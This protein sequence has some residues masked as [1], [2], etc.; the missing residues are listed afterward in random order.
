MRHLIIRKGVYYLRMRVPTDVRVYFPCKE[1]K[2]TLKTRD[3]KKACFLVKLLV[4]E[5]DKIFF[6]IRSGVLSHEEIQKL[7]KDY[8]NKTVDNDYVRDSKFLPDSDNL[9]PALFRDTGTAEIESEVYSFLKEKGVSISGDSAEF[10]T[11]C[12]VIVNTT[13][14]VVRAQNEGRYRLGNESIYL[15]ADDYNPPDVRSF[16]SVGHSLQYNEQARSSLPNNQRKLLREVIQEYM[17]EKRVTEAWKAKTEYENISLY[18]LF[19]EIASMVL[20]TENVYID[21]LNRDVLLSYVETLKRIPANMKKRF[22]D[23]PISQVLETAKKD[24]IKPISLRTRNKYI[25]QVSSLLK[26]CVDEKNYIDKNFAEN[27]KTKDDR[28]EHSVRDEYTLINLT[29]IF[30]NSPIYQ[31]IDKKFPETFFIPLIALYS[32]LRLDE[33]CQLYV[34]DIKEIDNIICFDVNDELDKHVKTAYSKRKVPIHPIII[35][36]GFLSYVEKLRR[37]K[38]VRVWPNLTRKRE[39][40]SQDFGKW[41]GRYNRKYITDNTKEVFHSF[42]HNVIN[43]LKQKGVLESIV[44]ELVGH[45]P[46]TLAMRRYGK[47]YKPEVLLET[48]K[49]LDYGLNLYG[50]KFPS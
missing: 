49:K 12:R 39:K 36:A 31:N 10:K 19:H 8:L 17:R 11:L 2:Q 3:F 25:V 22:K 28:L 21:E 32:G 26:W 47:Q 35:S 34:D 43:N 15:S 30:L 38:V 4:G 23:V 6:S 42:R 37:D 41:Y 50:L 46:K 7:V 27:L 20:H 1:I 13:L 29:K 48:I 40:Y 14:H 18:N 33:I 45:V 16:P 44:D 24:N 9:W 5:A